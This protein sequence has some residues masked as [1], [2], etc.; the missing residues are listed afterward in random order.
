MSVKQKLNYYYKLTKPGIVR[1]NSISVIAGFFLASQGDI[2][3]W[4]L[5]YT[6]I[7]SGLVMAGGCVLNNYIDRDTDARME[8]TKSRALASHKI[9]PISALLYGGF[10]TILGFII[11]YTQT[12]IQAVYVGMLG[13]V[14]YVYIYGY[15]KRRTEHGTLVGSISGAVPPVVGYLAVSGSYDIGALLVF[16]ILVFW[17]MPHFYAIAMFRAKE[18]KTV[19]IPVLSLTRG[20]QVTRRYAVVYL[21]LYIIVSTLP[22]FYGLVN[23]WYLVI[24]LLSGLYWLYVTIKTYDLS[25]NKWARKVFGNSLLCLSSFC[26]AIIIGT[27]IQ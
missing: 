9:S 5:A 10:I 26:L 8:R 19:K 21:L 14:F 12:T 20:M 11:L 15:F 24:I 27:M 3:W 13:F 22:Y 18:Y 4:L 6:L 17:Q 1:G 25:D 7:A 16:L 2:D 23:I